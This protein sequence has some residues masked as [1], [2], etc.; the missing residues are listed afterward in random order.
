MRRIHKV[1]ISSL[2]LL[3]SIGCGAVRGATKIERYPDIYEEKPVSILVMPP[4][5]RSINVT[6]KELLYNTITVPLT[7]RGYYVFPT[8]LTLDILKEESA[9]DSE[10]FIENPLD[11]VGEFFGA[12]AVLFI[13]IHDW[14]RSNLA[15]HIKVELQYIIKSTKSNKVLFDRTGEFTYSP[16]SDGDS[17][18]GVVGAMVGI[19]A[20]ALSTAMTKEVEVARR[21]NEVL[22][23]D[24]PAGK[25]SSSFGKD[26]DNY[27]G[28]E[29]VRGEL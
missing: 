10:M 8:L 19:L 25:Y 2:L 9:Y 26:G 12:D 23:R 5:N 17:G 6:A 16:S 20:D 18:D 4:I 29:S 24:L 27:A 15:A 3:F 13:V 1:V 22:L 14:S 7:Q 21:C 28:K 11:K